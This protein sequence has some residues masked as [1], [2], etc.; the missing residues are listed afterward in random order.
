MTNITLNVLRQYQSKSAIRE[1]LGCLLIQPS[2]LATYRV[3]VEDFV[4]A[5]HKVVFVAINNCYENGMEKLDALIIE[6]YLKESF[7]TKYGIFKRNNGVLY[8][9]KA[10][11]MAT[12]ENIKANYIEMRK[13]TVL[14]EL[15]KQGTD[16]SEYFDPE[17]VDSDEI[18]K[19]RELFEDSSI[20]DI[21]TFYRSKLLRITDQFSSKNGSDS[22]KAG[23]DAAKKQKEEWKKSIAYGLS[24]ASD[25]LT[26]ITY[27]IRRK[28]YVLCSAGTGVGK[29][30]L[31]VA[32]LCKS[33]VPRYWKDG[34]WVENPHGTQNGAVY[35]GTEMELIEEVEPILWAYIADVP[36]EHILFGRY[37][38]GEEER[39]DEAIRIL[40][41]EARIYL[42]YVPDYNIA[43]LEK[44]IDR[45]V[46]E[47]KIG[48]VFFDYIHTTTDLI[49]EFQNAAKAH[50]QIQEFQVLKNLSTKI[51]DLTRKYNISIDTWTQV[52]GDFK[53]EQNYDETIVA[54][55]KAIPQK[56]DTCAVVS[57][58]TQKELKLLEKILKSP[59]HM[60]KPNPNVCYS[61]Y[62]NRGGK[63][64]RVKIWLY[65][66]YDTM[67]VHDQFVTDYEYN[68]LPIE[69]VYVG[70]N[71]DQKVVIST[72]KEEIRKATNKAKW[73]MNQIED[74][75][76]DYN[77]SD[78]LLNFES[79]NNFGGHGAMVIE[80]SEADIFNQP[81]E[82]EDLN[83]CD[84]K[85]VDL[86]NDEDDDLDSS[87][88]TGSSQ[89]NLNKD[90]F[91]SRNDFE[92]KQDKL[93]QQNSSVKFIPRKPKNRK[94]NL[95]DFD[96]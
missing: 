80:D 9:E 44:I 75:D 14:R 74:D 87:K 61:V 2:L 47:H 53:N 84:I 69:Q 94:I 54:G 31:S 57:R 81:E 93:P 29:T 49:S 85:V 46:T 59:V 62:K 96:W 15:I 33:F 37:E 89:N 42:E 58:P 19:K 16:V 32:N 13:F 91:S 3:S 12:I 20:D 5:F 35:I 24:Y 50:M 36:S 48:H 65:V 76:E 64:N 39:V 52:S 38:P 79:K 60:G 90:E 77:A 7:P 22:V 41:E 63:Y 21:L 71:E 4:E 88:A 27:G 73:E 10:Q 68:I 51:K 67:R 28:R 30:R 25:Y 34:K 86:L 40:N 83:G 70:I 26:A 82:Q 6:E 95:E 8:I 18:D 92:S 45:H 72:K 55:S 66:N 17:E 23:S 43:E 56:A 78:E 1:V 11:E